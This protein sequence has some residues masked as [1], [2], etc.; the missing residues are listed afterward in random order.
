LNLLSQVLAFI[1][2]SALAEA[3]R[4]TNGISG[5][6]SVSVGSKRMGCITNTAG[7]D[8]YTI[9]EYPWEG[10]FVLLAIFLMFHG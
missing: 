1:G 7:Y 9:K 6:L 2:R 5:Q 3:Y 10:I 8:S 4:V